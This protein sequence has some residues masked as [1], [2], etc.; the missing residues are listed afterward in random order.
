MKARNTDIELLKQ[1][2]KTME[3]RFDKIESI[4]SD[5]PEKLEK[6]F[7]EK[8][9]SKIEVV[10]LKVKTNRHDWFFATL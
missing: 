4:L 3:N 5:L 8:F 7:E 9:A 10:V 1:S 2:Y 6:S